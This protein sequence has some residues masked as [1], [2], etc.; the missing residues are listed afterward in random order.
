[1][2]EVQTPC[3]AHRRRRGPHGGPGL[4]ALLMALAVT[5]AACGQA[6][7]EQQA[8]PGTGD[9]RDFFRGA[10]DGVLNNLS[11]AR[12][13]REAMTEL[14]PFTWLR[15]E[16]QKVNNELD[17]AARLRIGFAWTALY[18]HAS[19]TRNDDDNA[20]AADFDFFGRWRP[21]Q[22][23][24]TLGYVIFQTQVRYELWQDQTPR[25]LG[26]EIG[27]LWGTANGFN[28]QSFN[29]RQL[30]WQQFLFN[31]ELSYRIGKVDLGDVF[32]NNRLQSDNHFFLNAA[33]SDNPTMAYPENDFGGDITW[34]PHRLVY[35]AA[36]AANADDDNNSDTS[37]RSIRSSDWFTVAE[38]GFTPWFEDLGAGHYRL[39]AWYT[40]AG[41]S[42]GA[43]SASGVSLSFDQDLGPRMLAF[44]RYGYTDG[45]LTTTE[46][47]VAGGMAF[48]RPFGKND[49]LAGIAAAWGRP[50]DDRLGD[51]SV[52]EAF[53]RFQLT[54]AIEVT[55]DL[56]LIIEPT[57][58]P[59]EDYVWV[60]GVR[61]R[62]T[63]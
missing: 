61:V 49:D 40:D 60:F 48:R 51:Q 37:N 27:S 28:T 34:R 2:F 58:A 1:M 29:L 19:W 21:L 39:T 50:A 15:N 6:E 62:I 14:D 5:G 54:P 20:A 63:F 36:G 44:L 46:Q 55:P 35:V 9:T 38:V 3:R 56:Q 25:E 52:V 11:A 4:S 43:S 17:R 53:Y 31:N 8:A 7:Q 33:F 18:Q 22:T 13:D 47:I 32:N 23:R 30:Y 59:E 26:R 24:Q 45:D 16:M 10:A 42:S 57:L 41:S 12:F